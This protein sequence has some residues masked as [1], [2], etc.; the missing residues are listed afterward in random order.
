[1]DPAVQEDVLRGSL[2]YQKEFDLLEEYEKSEQ[3]SRTLLPKYLQD[4]VNAAPLTV[5]QPRI[6]FGPMSKVVYALEHE[7]VRQ[8]AE[9]E[10]P[11]AA[12]QLSIHVEPSRLIYLDDDVIHDTNLLRQLVDAS[13]DHPQ[14]AVALTGTVLRD[15]FRQVRYANAATTNDKIPNLVLHSWNTHGEESMVVD[16]VKATTG[17]CLPMTLLNHTHILHDILPQMKQQK[18]EQE[19]D[20]LPDNFE[21]DDVILSAIL[22]TMNITRVLVPAVMKDAEDILH[23]RFTNFSTNELSEYGRDQKNE[24]SKAMEWMETLVFLQKKLGVWRQHIFLDPGKLT[25]KQ[26]QAIACEAL[27]ETD[28]DSNPNACLPSSTEC[29]D[30]QSI[31]SELEGGSSNGFQKNEDDDGVVR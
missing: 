10:S 6:V 20:K 11:D 23:V 27:H 31:L 25:A 18:P 24:Y 14:S 4:L 5:L 15:R 26:K 12:S 3:S 2:G 22:E 1:M 7:T 19:I 21:T 8:K 13:L 16:I 9:T 17:V 28:C 30:A 29:P